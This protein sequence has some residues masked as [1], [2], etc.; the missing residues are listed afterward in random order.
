M[1]ESSA[2]LGRPSAHML[3]HCAGSTALPPPFLSHLLYMP[4]CCCFSKPS[5]RP[6]PPLSY[7]SSRVVATVR[8]DVCTRYCLMLHCVAFQKGIVCACR[9]TVPLLQPPLWRQVHCPSAPVSLVQCQESRMLR[10]ASSSR[11]SSSKRA[12]AT[13]VSR[14]PPASPSPPGCSWLPAASPSALSPASICVKGRPGCTSMAQLSWSAVAAADL[15]F[16][17]AGL[18]SSMP[19]GGS[20]ALYVRHTKSEVSLPDSEQARSKQDSGTLVSCWP[21]R[22]ISLSLLSVSFFAWRSLSVSAV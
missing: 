20:S 13:A 18:C 19:P 4:P 11:V 10:S 7:D 12:G 15:C 9:A 22:R 8:L 1:N 21:V 5:S 14:L 16:L 2:C 17:L 6:S 3:R